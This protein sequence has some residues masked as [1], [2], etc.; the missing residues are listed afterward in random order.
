MSTDPNDI[1]RVATG[2]QVEIEL[3]QQTLREAGITSRVVGDD[4]TGGL[5]TAMPGSVE[6]WVH[7][8]DAPR[9]Q[10]A[11]THAKGKMSGV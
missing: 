4:L 3:H 8:S 11:L 9:A 5:G 2:S 1:V 6:L 7:A 10:V